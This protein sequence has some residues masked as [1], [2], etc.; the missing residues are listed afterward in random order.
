MRVSFDIPEYTADVTAWYDAIL[1]AIREAGI[2]PR[3]YQASCSEMFG[4]AQEVPQTEKT[5][6]WPR[7]PY[8]W[9]KFF[10]TGPPLIIGRVTLFTRA[11]PSF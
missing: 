4:N 2:R 9:Q 3:F 5:P 8:G 7:S 1:E 6:F 10:P 11:T